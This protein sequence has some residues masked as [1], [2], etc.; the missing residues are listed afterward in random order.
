MI[1]NLPALPANPATVRVSPRGEGEA[2]YNVASVCG[3]HGKRLTLISHSRVPH[4]AIVSVEYKDAIFLGEVITCTQD[5]DD[6]WHLEIEVEQ[7][8]NGLT[9]LLNL[10]ARLMGEAVPERLT[11]NAH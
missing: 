4:F 9:S 8:L 3:I 11:V 7:I 5:C 2:E 10:R 6:R 1:K